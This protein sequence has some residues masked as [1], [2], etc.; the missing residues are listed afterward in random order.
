MG[1]R[2]WARARP[3]DVEGLRRARIGGVSRVA[4]VAEHSGSAESR[5]SQGPEGMEQAAGDELG[6]TVRVATEN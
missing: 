1:I 3:R 4:T 6:C 5:V 2:A